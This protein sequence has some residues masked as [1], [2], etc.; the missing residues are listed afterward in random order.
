MRAPPQPRKSR[1]RY[2][3]RCLEKIYGI[4]TLQPLMTRWHLHKI[5]KKSRKNSLF[6]ARYI[7][8]KNETPT[9]QEDIV[10]DYICSDHKSTIR[11]PLIIANFPKGCNSSP[12]F[13]VL[14]RNGR[15]KSLISRRKYKLKRFNAGLLKNNDPNSCA[16]TIHLIRKDVC[17]YA[18]LKV[19]YYKQN[20]VNTTCVQT[21][22][23]SIHH[24]EYLEFNKD[25][26]IRL[27]DYPS[28]SFRTVKHGLNNSNFIPLSTSKDNNKMVKFVHDEKDIGNLVFPT[29]DKEELK[30]RY[31]ITKLNKSSAMSR[32]LGSNFDQIVRAVSDLP[33]EVKNNLTALTI[34]KVTS[35]I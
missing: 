21:G 9:L 12:R 20:V 27:D 4:I 11:K 35:G 19:N 26:S 10:N 16:K 28:L 33:P 2:A 30:D 15:I 24:P 13:K 29:S 7:K 14:E 22:D 5:H 3:H 6:G 31:E 1:Y 23:L 34:N 32:V 17:R 18:D 25:C 8:E